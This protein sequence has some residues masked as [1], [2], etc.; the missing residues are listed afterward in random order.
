MTFP[1]HYLRDADVCRTLADHIADRVPKHHRLTDRDRRAIHALKRLAN[2][3]DRSH[4]CP[5]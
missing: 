1:A 4:Q 3:L 2:H 5:E